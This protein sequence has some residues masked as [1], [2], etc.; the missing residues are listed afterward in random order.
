[1]L[2]KILLFTTLIASTQLTA[3]AGQGTI[4]ETDD[5]IIIEYSGDSDEDVKAVIKARELQEKQ[6][7]VDAKKR[8]ELIEQSA[9]K[10]KAKDA[11]RAQKEPRARSG[12]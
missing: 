11:I 7:E 10:A 4:R 9:Q 2:S 8:E 3:Q 6:A 12:E 1:M 5:A